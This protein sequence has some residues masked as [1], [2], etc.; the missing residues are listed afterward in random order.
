MTWISLLIW[1]KPVRDQHVPVDGPLPLKMANKLLR[2]MVLIVLS[3][4]HG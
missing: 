4:E 3:A 1:F 2:Y